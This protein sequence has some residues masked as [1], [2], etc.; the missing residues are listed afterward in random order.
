MLLKQEETS[1]GIGNGKPEP[2]SYCT[3][4]YAMNF[5][6]KELESDNLE[7]SQTSH[8]PIYNVTFLAQLMIFDLIKYCL[9]LH[10]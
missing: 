4:V 7:K 6:G 8:F 10:L 5:E 1:L 9:R 3:L 2:A